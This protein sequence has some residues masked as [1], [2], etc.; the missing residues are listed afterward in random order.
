MGDPENVKFPQNLHPQITI[1]KNTTPALQTRLP[2]SFP[3]P[4]SSYQLGAVAAANPLLYGKSCRCMCTAQRG[5]KAAPRGRVPRKHKQPPEV[6]PQG[7]E[8]V[9][10]H[11]YVGS[12]KS[13]YQMPSSPI[14][15]YFII[16]LKIAQNKDWLPAS[17]NNIEQ[18]V[19]ALLCI[20]SMYHSLKDN[21]QAPLPLNSKIHVGGL[22][23]GISWDHHQLHGPP[24]PLTWY[25]IL[26]GKHNTL[27][28]LF[29]ISNVTKI[30][31]FIDC[32]K[33]VHT[34]FY[35]MKPLCI[36]I[37]IS[38]ILFQSVLQLFGRDR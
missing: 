34:L 26:V 18:E 28:L 12:W 20:T 32:L 11:A 31:N 24:I 13:S 5:L 29:N 36:N 7:Q 1:K 9:K 3:H 35:L 8:Q 16:F 30:E 10:I 2:Q 14:D 22:E 21:E 38:V 37:F 17:I 4:S 23:I 15:C 27:S 6:T 19:G 33:C 25:D